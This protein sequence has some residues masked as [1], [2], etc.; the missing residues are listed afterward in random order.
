MFQ[1]LRPILTVLLGLLLAALSLT[2]ASQ[3]VPPAS[4]FGL[5]LRSAPT[6]FWLSLFVL[7][8]AGLC[9]GVGL[10][11]SGCRGVRRRSQQLRQLGLTQHHCYLSNEEMYEGHPYAR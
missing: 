2:Y 10:V 7:S 3:S 4:D 8:V 1:I 11:C 6:L 9:L 5:F